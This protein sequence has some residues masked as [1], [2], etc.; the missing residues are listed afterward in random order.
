MARKPGKMGK[1]G[2]LKLAASVAAG[3][4]AIAS[5]ATLAATRRKQRR[6]REEGKHVPAGPYEAVIKRPL[7]AA[8]AAGSLVVLSPLLAATALVVRVKLGSPVIFAQ[9][10]PGKEGKVFK[11]YKFR[12]MTDE[13]DPETGE[14][15][16]DEVRLT[17]LGQKLRAY[18][19][20]ELPELV[21]ILKG[22]MA[23]IG[24]RPLLVQYLPLY[25]EEQAHRHDVRPGLTGLAQISGRN[26]LQWEEKFRCDV[27]YVR[28]CTLVMDAKIFMT[29]FRVIVLRQGIHSE[30]SATME[31][32]EGT[33]EQLPPPPDEFLG[34][35]TQAPDEPMPGSDDPAPEHDPATTQ[36]SSTPNDECPLTADPHTT[37]ANLDSLVAGGNCS[38]DE[39]EIGEHGDEAA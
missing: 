14:L 26:A 31:A 5:A 19:L 4:S 37:P 33:Q 2:K 11:L 20:D 1:L 10:R 7:G 38:R 22:D 18:S 21:N 8:M 30:T 39:S 9:Q 3:A 32:F 15:L 35:K 25:S 23:L 36:S 12:T 16:P 27:E 28:N 29:T 17:P 34:N 6:A 24:P 13:R